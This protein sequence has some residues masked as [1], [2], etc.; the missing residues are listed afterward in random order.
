MHHARQQVSVHGLLETRTRD[1]IFPEDQLFPIRDPNLLLKSDPNP[2]IGR[3]PTTLRIIYFLTSNQGPGHSIFTCITFD[4]QSLFIGGGKLLVQYSITHSKILDEFDI[5]QTLNYNFKQVE[6]IEGLFTDSHN[7]SLFIVHRNKSLK[8]SAMSPNTGRKGRNSMDE[9]GGN[10]W[11]RMVSVFSFGSRRI[12]KQ[13]CVNL[14]KN[15]SIVEWV[16]ERT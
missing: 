9:Y 11:S 7:D 12:I 1:P 6:R 16:T 2:P 3:H 15:E 5:S 14:Y 10:D 8:D 13:F 4:N